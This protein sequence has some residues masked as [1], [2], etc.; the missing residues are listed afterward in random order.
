VTRPIHTAKPHTFTKPP[1]IGGWALPLGVT[2][3]GWTKTIPSVLSTYPEFLIPL[4][5]DKPRTKEVGYV[6]FGG[7][8]SSSGFIGTPAVLR[9]TTVTIYITSRVCHTGSLSI[10]KIWVQRIFTLF[11]KL[12]NVCVNLWVSKFVLGISGLDLI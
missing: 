9:S 7:H 3:F 6:P 11:Y 1:L 12:F 2:F 4:F 8:D 5:L 10:T